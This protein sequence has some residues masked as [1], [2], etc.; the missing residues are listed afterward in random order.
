[1]PIRP[2]RPQLVKS[3]NIARIAANS[4]TPRSTPLVHTRMFSHTGPKSKD[5]TFANQD[6]LP[7]LPVPKLEDALEVYFKSLQPLLEQ[8]VGDD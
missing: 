3:S 4:S 5:P 1:M 7:R 2:F 8:K 6:K